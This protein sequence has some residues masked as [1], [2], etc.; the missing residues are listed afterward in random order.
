MRGGEA[1]TYERYHLTREE[2]EAL[3][4]EHQSIPAEG[5]QWEA[6]WVVEEA[7]ELHTDRLCRTN[8]RLEWVLHWSLQVLYLTLFTEPPKKSW[9]TS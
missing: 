3:R 7:A 6:Q 2:L 1:P 5:A 4:A 9:P 8:T